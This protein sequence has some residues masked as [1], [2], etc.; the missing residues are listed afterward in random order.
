MSTDEATIERWQAATCLGITHP[1]VPPPKGFFPSGPWEPVH[2][3]LDFILWKRPLFRI[4]KYPWDDEK[5]MRSTF[6]EYAVS[7]ERPVRPVPES[8][9]VDEEWAQVPYDE[10]C[11]FRVLSRVRWVP[12]V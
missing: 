6:T 4:P 10:T 1:I 12:N 2:G 5:V 8:W 11:W 7:V 9:A 3:S